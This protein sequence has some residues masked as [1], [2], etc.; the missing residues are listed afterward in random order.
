MKK[1]ILVLCI[2]RDNDLFEKAKVSGPVVGREKNLTAA[3][4]LALADPEDADSNAMFY[5]IKVH[6][7]MKKEGHEAEVVTCTGDKSLGYAA[8]KTLSNQLDRVV[9]EINPSSCVLIS[10][11]ASD[12]EMLPIIKSRIK[13]D[14]T[15]IVFVKQAKELEKTYFVLIEKLKDPYYAKILLGIPALLMLLFSVSSYIGLGWQVIGVVIGIYLLIRL[16]GIDNF[17]MRILKEFRFS[18]EK[19]SWISYIGAFSLLMV[20]A[21]I[22]YQS[23]V[24]SQKLGLSGEKVIAYATSRTVFLVLIAVILAMAGKTIDAIHEGKKFSITKYSMYMI[25]ATL[26]VLVLKISSDWVLNLSKPYV[27]FSDLLLVLATSTAIGYVSTKVIS[28][29]KRDMLINMRLD[30]KEAISEQGSYLGKIVGVDVKSGSLIIQ[31][32]FD[33]KYTIPFGAVSTISENVVLKTGES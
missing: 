15:K 33:K 14:S 8:D 29:I 17:I 7:E 25:G 2:D 1:P 13:I 19:T 24:Y 12:E 4:A 27:Y 6:D 10:D 18:V 5:A 9:K 11:G 20:G 23:V 26:A 22:C 30:G 32:I 28:E 31:T 3:C 16:F 21:L